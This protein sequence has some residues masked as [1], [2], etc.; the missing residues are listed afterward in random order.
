VPVLADIIP[1]FHFLL[2]FAL[3]IEIMMQLDLSS[4]IISK[5]SLCN[6]NL[7]KSLV[8]AFGS[9]AVED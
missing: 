7:A 2:M 9:L 1:R 8:I 3:I 5:Y 6:K 4:E